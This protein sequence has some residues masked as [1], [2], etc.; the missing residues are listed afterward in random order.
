MKSQRPYF[1]KGK[2]INQIDTNRILD[3]LFDAVLVINHSGVI[4]YI[5]KVVEQV[6]KIEGETLVGYDY[7]ELLK[8]SYTYEFENFS[9]FETALSERK[10]VHDKEL[11]LIDSENNEV[12]IKGNTYP[13]YEGENFLGVIGVF[14]D[15]TREKEYQEQTKR[16]EEKF[17]QAEK[18]AIVGE[19]AAG[20]AHE[21]KNPL[22]TIKGFL[23]LLESNELPE[24][25]RK[26]YLATITD[27]VNRMEQLVKEFLHLSK[28]SN[29]EE[30]ETN[31]TVSLCKVFQKTLI[32]FSPQFKNKKVMLNIKCPGHPIYLRG[33]SD[34]L[35]QVFINL[36]KNSL[37]A[38]EK[39]PQDCRKLTIKVDIYKSNNKDDKNEK[40]ILEFIDTGPGIPK[41]IM[42]KLFSPFATTKVRGTGLGLPVSIQIIQ[43]LGGYLVAEN[44]PLRGACFRIELPLY[45]V[46]GVNSIC[47]NVYIPYCERVA[48]YDKPD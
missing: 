30:H 27:E 6:L 18:L 47:R 1:Q 44:S 25:K 41:N 8:Y 16:W 13:I 12:I 20:T 4:T 28:P 40:V 11:H 37:E 22:A 29:Q 42:N 26:E 10:A 19:M 43:N 45:D 38:M 9:I 15:I 7:R 5:N 21:I 46:D 23:Q 32:F 3:S 24:S 39:I 36:I 33:K 35:Q 48:D 31:E 2:Y 14:R 34:K 17:T